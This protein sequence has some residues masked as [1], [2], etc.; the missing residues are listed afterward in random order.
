ML[1]SVKGIIR[2]NTVLIEDNIQMYDGANVIV[3]ILD[4]PNRE[5]EKPSVDWDSFVKPSD[6]GLHVDEYMAEM[7]VDDK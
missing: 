4:Y 1:T 5:N 7:R 6:R 2:G 3:T